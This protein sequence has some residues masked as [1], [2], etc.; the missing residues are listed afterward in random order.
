MYRP[1]K[2]RRICPPFIVRELEDRASYCN[3]GLL[4]VG[5]DFEDSCMVWISA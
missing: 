5:R 2:V 3:L 1:T 4:Q